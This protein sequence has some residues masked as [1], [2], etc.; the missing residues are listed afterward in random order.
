[1]LVDLPRS[2]PRSFIATLGCLALLAEHDLL[3]PLEDLS[4]GVDV[5]RSAIKLAARGLDKSESVP[6]LSAAAKLCVR[7]AAR[8]FTYSSQSR[9][10]RRHRCGP[11]RRLDAGD[12]ASEASPV[13]RAALAR[14][15]M[16]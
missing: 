13:S 8:S 15:H 1:M 7:I 9:A 6:R 4:E 10:T 16:G 5:L 3:A 14:A 11:R 12:V 2:A